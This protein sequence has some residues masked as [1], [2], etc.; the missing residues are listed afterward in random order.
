MKTLLSWALLLS[1]LTTQAFASTHDGLKQAFDELNYSLSV[2]WDQKDQN[3]QKAAFEKFAGNVGALK[4][5]K[6]DFTQFVKT[7]MKEDQFKNDLLAV[8][9]LSKNMSQEE[10]TQYLFD[11]MKANYDK[12][13]SW[14]G[15]RATL[16]I[17]GAIAYL[18]IFEIIFYPRSGPY[19]TY[20]PWAVT[21]HP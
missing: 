5:T 12:G 2:E 14:E 21:Y 15:T 11:S 8:M 7:E 17:A 20:Y 4:L 13:A 10:V 3:F 18:V 1:V 19:W 6:E 16:W 9:S